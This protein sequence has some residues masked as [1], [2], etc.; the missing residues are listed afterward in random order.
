VSISAT[1]F[2]LMKLSAFTL[3]AALSLRRYGEWLG[4]VRGYRRLLRGLFP[5]EHQDGLN[6]EVPFGPYTYCVKPVSWLDWNVLFLGRYEPEMLDLMAGYATETPGGVFVDV[7]ANVGHHSLFMARH[8]AAVHAFEPYPPLW[9]QFEEKLS[10]ND[11]R[12]VVLHR[13]GLGD[14]DAKLNFLPPPDYNLGAGSFAKASALMQTEDSQGMTDLARSAHGSGCLPSGFGRGSCSFGGG[15]WPSQPCPEAPSAGSALAV[16]RGDTYLKSAGVDRVDILKIDVEGGEAAVLAG[17]RDVLESCRPMVVVEINVETLGSPEILSRYLPHHYQIF[18]LD[19][20]H[21]L[22][23]RLVP[24][25]MQVGAA[26]PGLGDGVNVLAVP[27]E[28]AYRLCRL[29]PSRVPR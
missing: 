6:L 22:T 27:Q 25:R 18:V 19:R 20:A 1:Y 3:S 13:I 28:K 15:S 23:A 14:A 7:G 4:R 5:P 9:E 16:R 11:L 8:C 10:R 21:L 26:W 12:N 24:R 29:R 2:R 17:L